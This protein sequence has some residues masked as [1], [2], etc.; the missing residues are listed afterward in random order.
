MRML[1]DRGASQQLLVIAKNMICEDCQEAHMPSAKRPTTIESANKLWE[2]MQTDNMM[3]TVG[4][5]VYHFQLMMDEASSYAVVFK[6]QTTEGRNATSE[7]I[8]ES[9]QSRWIQYFGYQARQR[10]STSWNR[11]GRLG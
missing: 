10:R 11:S 2:V 8:M 4:N 3:I 6:H 7:E 9:I 1:Q 5:E